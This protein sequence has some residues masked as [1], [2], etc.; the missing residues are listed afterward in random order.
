MSEFTK[1]IAWQKSVDLVETI[2]RITKRFPEDEK[3]GLVTQI[4]RAAVSI[5]SNIAEGHGRKTDGEFNHFLKI[6]YGSSSELETQLVISFRLKLIS[7]KEYNEVRVS[8]EEVRKMIH[9]L[10][11]HFSNHKTPKTSKHNN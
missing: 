3:F 11:L 1:L 5:P 4:R 10:I 2:Y 7:D 9:G 8:L 6:A